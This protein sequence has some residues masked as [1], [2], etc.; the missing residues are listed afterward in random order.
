VLE[1]ELRKAKD[2]IRSL[3]AQLT[4]TLAPGMYSM[5]AMPRLSGDELNDRPTP[6]CPARQKRRL[7]GLRGPTRE[8]S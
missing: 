1:Y 3:R 7:R 2:T 6:T 8:M 4:Q 5:H